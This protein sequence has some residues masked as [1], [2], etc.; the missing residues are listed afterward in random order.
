MVNGAW[1]VSGVGGQFGISPVATDGYQYVRI[2]GAVA[3]DDAFM[4]TGVDRAA[5]DLK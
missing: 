3:A 2:A 5:S 4:V 1:R